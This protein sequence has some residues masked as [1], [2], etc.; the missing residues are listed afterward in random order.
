MP[1]RPHCDYH[2]ILGIQRTAD[3]NTIKAAYRKLA[4]TKHPDRNKDA[5]ATAEF[6]LASLVCIS[7]AYETLIDDA[8]RRAYNSSTFRQRSSGP[9]YIHP[10]TPTSTPAC[11]PPSHASASAQTQPPP[12]GAR[13]NAQTASFMTNEQRIYHQLRSTQTLLDNTRARLSRLPTQ[14][15]Q[16]KKQREQILREQAADERWVVT[17]TASLLRHKD[18]IARRQKRH[19]KEIAVLDEEVQDMERE[20]Q[21]LMRETGALDQRVR[22]LRTM[23][24]RVIGEIG[25]LQAG[26]EVLLGFERWGWTST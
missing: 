4:L 22:M 10:S 21:A 3:V 16:L 6:Q 23:R 17:F 19:D 15:M 8:K 9:A 14:I 1:Q 20:L 26:P 13:I 5:N 11:P 18:D 24:G 2:A 7:E 25:R 12:S